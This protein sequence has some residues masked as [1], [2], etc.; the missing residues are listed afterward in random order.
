MRKLRGA[1]EKYQ[2]LKLPAEVT[3][4]VSA[5]PRLLYASI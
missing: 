2:S 4:V 1:G 3:D 5:G